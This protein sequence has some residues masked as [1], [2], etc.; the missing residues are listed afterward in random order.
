M[1][2]FILGYAVGK[3]GS[4]RSPRQEARYQLKVQREL[5]IAKGAPLTWGEWW[6]RPAPIGKI[7]KWVFYV[8]LFLLAVGLD[9]RGC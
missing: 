6:L 8:F 9:R 1:F 2:G 3:G 7:L 4:R 5:E